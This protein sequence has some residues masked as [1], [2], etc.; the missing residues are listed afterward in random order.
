MRSFL[1]SADDLVRDGIAANSRGDHQAAVRAFTHALKKSPRSMP[2][3]ANRATSYS[4]L[5]EYASALADLDRAIALVPVM[6]ALYFN[7]GG[8]HRDIGN[9][10]HALTDYSK[11]IAMDPE[12]VA[13]YYNRAILLAAENPEAALDDL[14]QVL[15][16]KPDYYP[17]YAERAK[18]YEALGRADEAENDR[19]LY[20]LH[21][22]YNGSSVDSD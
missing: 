17:V 19:R 8:V 9:W 10:N 22:P 13:A 16:L 14:A 18:I 6:P 4:A 20:R 12:M 7:R 1:K 11:A 2:A 3:L 5:G 21:Q 15:E